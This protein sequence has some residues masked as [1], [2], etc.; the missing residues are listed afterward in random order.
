MEY[1]CGYSAAA[2]VFYIDDLTNGQRD[3]QGE[4]S[5]RT[6]LGRIEQWNDAAA[7][8]RDWNFP[9]TSALTG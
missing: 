7:E 6:L 4:D 5:Q 2:Y 3:T 8:Y 9:G 1:R